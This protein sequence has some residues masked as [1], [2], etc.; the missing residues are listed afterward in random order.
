[1]TA[2]KLLVTDLQRTITESPSNVVLIVG[3]GV[4]MGALHGSPQYQ[5]A[6]WAG[7]LHDGLNRCE[8]LG[9]VAKDVRRYRELLS[10]DDPEAWVLAAEAISSGLGG[11][12]SGE[13]S[14]WLRETVGTFAEASGDNDVLRSIR[15]L[16]ERGVVLATVNYD[17]VLERATGLPPVT[18]RQRA[19]VERILRG[20]ERGILHLHGYWDDT[21]SVIL[22]VRS[23]TDVVRDEHA[24]EV[25][26]TLRMS[27]TL[28]LV[29]HGAGLRD[30]NWS[31]F[32]RWTERVFATGEYRHYRLALEGEVE[33]VRAEH[34][35]DQRI[36]PLSYGTAHADLGPFLAS[37]VPPAS[38]EQA[39]AVVSAE[40]T[41]PA[42]WVILRLNIRQPNYDPVEE[43]EVRKLVDDPD[44]VCLEFSCVVTDL[45]KTSPREWRAIAR[46]LDEIVAQAKAIDGPTQFIIAGRAPLPV[47]AYLGSQMFRMGPNVI[48]NKFGPIWERYEA[49]ESCPPDGRDDATIIPPG[50]GFNPSGRLAIAVHASKEYPDKEQS[51]AEL[52]A[53]E[54]VRLV[55]TYKIQNLKSS[56]RVNPLTPAEL[57]VYMG[58]LEA[59]LDWRKQAFPQ[60]RGLVMAI[61]GPAWLA[62][63]IGHRLNPNVVGGRIDFPNHGEAGYV[64]A[65]SNPM[66]MAP[67][68]AGKARLQVMNAEPTDQVRVQGAKNFDTIQDALRRELGEDGPFALDFRGATRVREFMRDVEKFNPDVLHLHLHGRENGDLAFEGANT[69]T[70]VVTAS[71]FVALLQATGVQPALIVLSPCYSAMVLAPLLCGIA[72]CV[73]A[74]KGK[75]NTN[76]A[77]QFGHYFY[78]ALARGNTLARAIEQG[79]AGSEAEGV[80]VYTVG[81]V[82]TQDIVLLP[83]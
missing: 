79:I 67:W 23:Y 74:M 4:S 61:A 7:L 45:A 29:G 55:G 14:R 63:W 72:E 39:K 54:Q 17:G 65:L 38:R 78:E 2:P 81:D 31:S 71:R 16:S 21:A 13:F 41:R 64:R 33:Q 34:P 76:R 18:W 62:F 30:P 27:R 56:H 8:A 77:I 10:S 25:L 47:F 52:L 69:E 68:L 28:L 57:P 53:A 6:S 82:R 15:E 58:H 37:L 44:P 46:G 51:I 26:Q 66:H 59:A 3:A 20:D 12:S 40:P 9:L 11:P 83:G 70:D 5:L 80:E 1:M 75:A 24:R 35:R 50:L 36:F 73:I 42:R 19:R 43:V 60:G 48:V 49:P 22:G 32:L